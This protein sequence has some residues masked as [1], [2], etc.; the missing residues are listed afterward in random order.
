MSRMDLERYRG[1]GFGAGGG[2]I[3]GWENIQ[4]KPSEVRERE[5]ARAIDFIQWALENWEVS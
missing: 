2:G 3:S 4:S 1:F 5:K